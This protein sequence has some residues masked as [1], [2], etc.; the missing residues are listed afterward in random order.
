[1]NTLENADGLL[2]IFPQGYQLADRIGRRLRR[3]WS[4]PEGKVRARWVAR[5]IAEYGYSQ[6]QIALEVPAGAGRNAET[7][8]VHADIVAYRDRRRREPFVVVE[9]KAPNERGG[10]L[11]AESYAR[12]LGADYHVW[13]D[14]VTHRFFRTAKYR[15]QSNAV[16]NI[17]HWL[18]ENP[19]GQRLA[20]TQDLPP[21]KDEPHLRAVVKPQST[22]E[23]SV[24]AC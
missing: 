12:N 16:G 8:T 10:V 24:S 20:K 13:S 22:E 7:S 14:G 17:P 2:S 3:E 18:G 19:V 21:F 15:N 4:Q 11:Q 1:M 9:T 5:L 23:M 6:E